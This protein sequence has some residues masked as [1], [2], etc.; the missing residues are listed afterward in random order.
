LCAQKILKYWT[1]YNKFQSK[2]VFFL[3][4]YFVLV[5]AIVHASPERH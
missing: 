5:A 3:N 1:K 2:I 4:S